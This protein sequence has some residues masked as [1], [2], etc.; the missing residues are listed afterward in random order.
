MSDDTQKRGHGRPRAVRVDDPFEG[1]PKKPVNPNFARWEGFEAKEEDNS[2]GSQHVPPEII[3]EG[4]EYQWINDSVHGEKQSTRFDYERTG[5]MPVPA[6]RPGHEGRWTTAGAT[7]EIIYKGQVL[8]ERPKY[9]SD[10]ARAKEQRAAREQV[11]IK[12]NQLK[13]GDIK[14]V[15]LDAQHPRA[16]ATNRISKTYEPVPRD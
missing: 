3:P 4:I 9:M 14:G 16:L 15:N 8:M 2:F 1:A 10:R 5:W 6:D 7:G 11:F 13:G 12:E